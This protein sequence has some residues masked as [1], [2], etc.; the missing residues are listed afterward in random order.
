MSWLKDIPEAHRDKVKLLILENRDLR[1]RL[2]LERVEKYGPAAER[3]SD[4]QLELLEL[5]PG[6]NAAEVEAEAQRGQL[7]LA[8]KAKSGDRTRPTGRQPL[9]PELPRVEQIIACS[10]EQCICG[11]CGKPTVVI[12]YETAERLD[13]E[14][15]KYFVRVLKREKRACSSC[16][17]GGVQTAALPA[18]IIEKSIVSDRVIIDTVI[19]KYCDYQPL[20]RQSAILEREVG[21]EISRTTMCDWVKQVGELLRPITASMR[22]ELLTGDYLQ[23]DETPLMVQVPGLGR[24]HR[25]YLWQYSRPQGNVVFDFQMGRGREGPRKFLGNY[26]GIL[27]TDG[28]SAYDEVGGTKVIRA[29]CWSHARRKF[30]QA[31]QVDPQQKPALELVATIDELFSIEARAQEGRFDARQRLALRQAEAGPWLEKIKALALEARKAALPRS[32]LA[33]GC[34]YLLK[35]WKQLTS[36]LQHGQL[37]LSTNL[38]ENAIRPIALGRK[39]WIHL[40]CQGAGPRIAAI[41]S[42]IETCRRLQ[43]RPRDYFDAILP[44]LADFPVNCVAELTPTVWVQTRL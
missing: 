24:N 3:L 1:E 8:L 30:F 7:Q 26:E 42:V 28:Y 15:A 6:V 18:R 14:P 27:Q 38:A 37:E 9:P 19:A 40:G 22:Q 36:F 11:K 12:G 20:Y 41:I 25:A 35:R 43:I 23:A 2:R 44:G 5:E 39:N 32:R 21:L 33:E 10:Q 13:R 4:A 31:L 16:A 17:Q 34:D 29:G